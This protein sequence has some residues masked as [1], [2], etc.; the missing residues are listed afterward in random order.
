MRLIK[1]IYSFKFSLV[2]EMLGNYYLKNN[3]MKE[4]NYWFVK[5][6]ESLSKKLNCNGILV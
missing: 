5:F 6:G 1:V 2:I 3:Y 4:K